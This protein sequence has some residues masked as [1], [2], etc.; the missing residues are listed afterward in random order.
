MDE[1]DLKAVRALPADALPIDIARAIHEQ[2][3]GQAWNTDVHFTENPMYFT[4][5]HKV[6]NRGM[7]VWKGIDA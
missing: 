7:P 2:E 5:C 4:P 1:D 3:N 6:F